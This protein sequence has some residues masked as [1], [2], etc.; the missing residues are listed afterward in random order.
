MQ[1]HGINADLTVVGGG[2]AG[3]CAAIAAARLG[4]TVALVQNRPVLGG[5]SSSEVRVWVCGAT[6]HGTQRYARETGIIGELF[7]ENQYVNQEGN[8]HLWDLVLIEAVRRESAI[9]LFLNTDVHH[10]HKADDGSIAALTGWQMGSERELTFT[11][12]LFLDC[13][14]DGLI[15]AL[16]GAAHR[17]GREAAGEYGETLAPAVADAA[18]LGSTILFY[19]KDA[20]RP[21]PFVPPSFAADVGSSTIP[22]QRVIRSGDNGC[23]YWWIEC[24]GDRDTIHDNEAIRD[25]LWSIVYGIWD[26]IKNSGRFPEAEHQTLEWVGAMPGKR[27]SRRFLGDHVLTQDDILQQVHFDDGV[28]FGGWSI[29]LHPPKGVF[30]TGSAS[31]HVFSDGVYEIPY[32]CLYS[33]DVG[34]L[35]FAGRNLSA[36]HVAFASTRVMA[37]CAALGEAAGTAAALCAERGV[38]PRGLYQHHRHALV[39]TLLRQDACVVGVRNEDPDDLARS[40]QVSASSHLAAVALTH[41]GEPWPLDTDAALTLPVEQRLDTLSLLLS[42]EHD[43]TLT[44]DVFDVSRPQNFVPRALLTSVTTSVP[45]GPSQWL[46][47]P[48]GVSLDAPAFVFVV[49]RAAPGVALHRSAEPLTGVLTYAHQLAV[50]S[51]DANEGHND[52]PLRAWNPKPLHRS[53]FCVRVTPNSRSYAPENVINGLVRPYGAPNLW[54]SAHRDADPEPWLALTWPTP[55]R[56]GRVLLTFN[57]DLNEDLINLHHHR[58]PFRVIPELVKDY[59]LL[60]RQHGDW[61]SVARVQDHRTRR[62]VHQLDLDDVEALRLL[63]RA[64]N[65]SAYAEVYEVRVYGG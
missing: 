11:S 60:A 4:R 29:D 64:T 26:F 45:A 42:A 20:G 2:L 44:L 55:Q 19:T 37:T 23:A 52:Q 58:T 3:T 47:V 17:I 36:S 10:L 25:D 18:V 34:N 39:Q 5:N 65:G 56:L 35:L 61:R 14:G 33:R 16:A 32:R 6:S 38:S 21:V 40:A 13:T 63:V 31:S 1:R 46:E 27:E 62:A 8:P 43:T 24:G 28:A 51:G 49:I 54:L 7:L 41:P 59:E 9:S 50:T 15:G 22:E 48:I 57:D 53:P 30:D 12:Q